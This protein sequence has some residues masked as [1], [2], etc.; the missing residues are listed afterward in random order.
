MAVYTDVS[1]EALSGFLG[2]YE[3]GPLVAFRG[4]AEGVE[5]SNFSLRTGTGDFILTLYEK[6]VEAAELPWFL[7]LM[8]HLATRG[9]TC[10]QPVPGR[11][12]EALRRLAGRPAA[13][14]SF[15]P[16]VWPRRVRPEHCRPLGEALARLHV[17]GADYAPTRPNRLGPD[18]WM[19]LLDSCRSSGDRVQPGLVA[20]L[21]RALERILPA[22]P[23]P[24]AARAGPCRPVPGQRVLPA[25]ARRA[26]VA[27][28]RDAVRPDRLLLRLHRPARL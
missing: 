22:W 2:E 16:G 14:T 19:P 20:E 9:V 28:R 27:A 25:E 11:D 7:G 26:A 12:G 21:D 6:R 17:A 13:I 24:A 15:L 18:S 5:N 10:P 4:I 8:R 1:D 3:L 23:E